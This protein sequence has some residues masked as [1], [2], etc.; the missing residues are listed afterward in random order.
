MDLEFAQVRHVLD[1]HGNVHQNILVAVEERR[2]KPI[3]RPHDVDARV[4]F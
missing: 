2:R 3:L 4:R 1:L